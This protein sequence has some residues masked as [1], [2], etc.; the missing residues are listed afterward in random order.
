MR[1][2]GLLDQ[3]FGQLGAFGQHVSH[4]RSQ[5]V[6][7]LDDPPVAQRIMDGIALSRG[8]DQSPIPEHLQVA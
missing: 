3:H 8:L 6:Q 5:Q 2:G 4:H 7:R 1:V